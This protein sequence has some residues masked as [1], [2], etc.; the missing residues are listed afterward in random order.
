M[1]LPLLTVKTALLHQAL[2]GQLLDKMTGST[3]AGDAALLT[4]ALREAAYTELTGCFS[5]LF[6]DSQVAL[7]FPDAHAPNPA[8]KAA[9]RA[10]E[11][12]P[13]CRLPMLW[14]E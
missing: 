12:W 4:V 10:A 7:P 3:A 2:H 5:D 6:P 9:G 13:N 14:L 1:T 11:I 8:W